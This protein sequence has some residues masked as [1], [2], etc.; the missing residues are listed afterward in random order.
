MRGRLS[1][2]LRAENAFPQV[3]G[4][5]YK[6]TIQAVLLFGSEMRNISPASV[7]SLEGFHLRAARHMA[8]MMPQRSPNGTW[9]YPDTEEVLE[10][11][12]LYRIQ[13]YIGVTQ[14]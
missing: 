4:M 1:Q 9:T 11:A 10:L 5:F 2:F 14:S 13:K 3:F 6:A 12:G 8:G 7:H